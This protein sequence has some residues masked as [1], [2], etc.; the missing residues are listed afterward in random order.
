MKVS[1]SKAPEVEIM[2]SSLFHVPV[3]VARPAL[4]PPGMP[5]HDLQVTQT[6][7]ISGFFKPSSFHIHLVTGLFMCDFW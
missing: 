5:Q 2:F 1:A 4:H 7:H 3:K 6:D